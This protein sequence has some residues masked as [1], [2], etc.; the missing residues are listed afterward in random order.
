VKVK[1][2]PLVDWWSVLKCNTQSLPCRGE[3]NDEPR[4][5]N[6]DGGMARS[7]THLSETTIPSPHAIFLDFHH[8]TS[9]QRREV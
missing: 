1:V 2:K 9:R 4:P 8:E 6:F 3:G 7:T 5:C